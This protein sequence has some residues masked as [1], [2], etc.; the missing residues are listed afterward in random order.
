M[1]RPTLLAACLLAALAGCAYWPQHQRAPAATQASAPLAT[2]PPAG[3]AAP[4]DAADHAATDRT[5]TPAPAPQAAAHPA[6]AAAR[7]VYLAPGEL[8]LYR[9]LPPPP[10]AGSARERAELAELLRIQ[11]HRT[12][13]EAERARADARQSVFRFAG[14][15]GNPPG[16]TPAKLPRTEALFHAIGTAESMATG[17]VKQAWDRP[18]PFRIDKRLKPVVPEPGSPSYPSGHSTWATAVGIVLA[19]MVPEHR[20]AI[21]ARAEEFA[22]HRE[23]AGVH[24]PSDV[25]AGHLAGTALAAQLFAS[26][27]FRSDEA[28]AAAE[29]RAALGLPPLPARRA[30]KARAGAAGPM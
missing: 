23:V 3:A 1:R 2:T 11:A 15:L 19:D 5:A 22:Y 30:P 16:F 7:T 29:L 25:A 26:P 12:R 9:L 28:A 21:F 14:A 13:A 18:R 27:R 4:G 17:P 10:P 24:Y 6:H 8:D 20:A